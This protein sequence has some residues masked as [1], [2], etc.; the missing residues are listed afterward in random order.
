[1]LDFCKRDLQECES[2][3]E[4]TKFTVQGVL[5]KDGNVL[6]VSRKTDHQD[7]GLPGGKVDY[8]DYSLESAMAREILEETGIEV[9]M[10]SSSVIFAMHRNG[11]MG[12]TYIITEW[13]GEIYTEE[14]HVVK[15]T[16]FNEIINGS[17][18]IWN[19]L[20]ADSL[21]SIGIKINR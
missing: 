13:N 19:S 11:Y 7:F 18:G 15:W 20:V 1:M 12:F 14:P 17:F 8:T 3:P 6:A 21:E 16:T 4:G 2:Y 5:L 10:D 9:N